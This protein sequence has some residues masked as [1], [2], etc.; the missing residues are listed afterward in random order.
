M[1]TTL[2]Q[3]LVERV[4][5]KS[6]L[7]NLQD[8][9]ENIAATLAELGQLRALFQATV[10]FYRLVADRLPEPTRL[11]TLNSLATL[12][13]QLDVARRNFEQ[14]PRQVS[15]VRIM[16]EGLQQLS[17]TLRRA[18]QEYAASVLAPRFEL[19]KLVRSLPEMRDRIPV[20]DDLQRRLQFFVDSAP[21]N[22]DSLTEFDEK[23]NQ[24]ARHLS[25]LEELSSAVRDFLEKVT[26]GTATI[27]DLDAEALEWCRQGTRNAAFRITFTH[28]E[29]SL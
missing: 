14:E 11:S 9:A 13:S 4:E 10:G 2:A 21:N 5:H 29:R 17:S 15:A 18:W 23:R 12:G 26:A 24:L 1:I 22:W 28:Q 3:A 16:A 27:A 25:S 20:L 6:R 19:L 7:E 8:E